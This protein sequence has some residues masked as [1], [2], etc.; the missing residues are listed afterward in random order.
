MT[1]KTCSH[2]TV[3]QFQIMK[4]GSKLG[5]GRGGGGD[6]GK[7]SLK[8]TLQIANI[9]RPNAQQNTVVIAI[10]AVRDSHENIVRFLKG[11]LEDE[12][13]ALQSHSWRDK[14]IK[15]FLNGDYDFLC[16]IYGL[17]GPQG[18]YPCLWCLMPQRDM[19]KHSDMCQL[20]SLDSLLA[21]NKTFM[22]EGEGQKK[23]ANKY[24]NCVYSPLINIELDSQSTLFTYSVRGSIKTS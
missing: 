15:V 12:L 21:D 3:T 17:S 6:H 24:Y 9:E 11:G 10:A 4:Y 22:D 8:F 19:H 20:R 16:K 2:G 5:G 1:N 23:D 14:I 7:N 18:T 13:T